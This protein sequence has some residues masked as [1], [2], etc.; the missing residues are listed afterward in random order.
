MI[1]LNSKSNYTLFIPSWYPD[2]SNANNGIFIKKHAHLVARFKSV[3]VLYASADKSLQNNPFEIVEKNEEDVLETIVYFKPSTINLLTQI[4]QIWAFHKGFKEITRQYGKPFVVHN[5]VIFPAGFYALF[6]SIFYKIPLLITEHWSGYTDRDC[7]FEKLSLIFRTLMRATAKRATKISTVSSFLER[8]LSEKLRT[9]NI[10]I[11]PNVLNI[12]AQVVR[13]NEHNGIHALCIGNLND[14]EKNISGILRAMAVVAKKHPSLTLTLVGD[15][16]ERF[17]YEKMT[18]DLGIDQQVIFTGKVPN[19]QLSAIYQ[20]HDFYILNS[21]FETFN[22]A[23]AEALLNGLPVIATRCG[24]PEAFVNEGN[25]ILVD[26]NNEQQ[27]GEAIS[28]MVKNYTSYNTTTIA[29]LMKQ[30]YSND[31]VE[32]SFRELYAAVESRKKL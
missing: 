16:A 25:G 19:N 5:H 29:E 17:S 8:S 13:K 14:H 23:T 20:T 28:R 22:I 7:R 31:A 32:K 27:L 21:H 24:G 15:G 6:V 9:N 12:P 1:D 11:T 30:K 4:R 3:K 2:R 10:L 18:I 26:V